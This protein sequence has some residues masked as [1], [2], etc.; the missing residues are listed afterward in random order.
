MVTKQVNKPLTCCDLIG[1]A[2]P[3]L[4]KPDTGPHPKLVKGNNKIDLKLIRCEVW[5][6]INW[7]L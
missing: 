5:A 6:G 3:C 4:Q 7:L 1:C 2:S